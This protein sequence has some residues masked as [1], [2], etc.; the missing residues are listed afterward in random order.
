V[1]V[2]PKWGFLTNHAHVLIEITRRPRATIREIALVA[3][4]TER[5]TISVLHDL[6][7]EG[8][9]SSEREGRRNVYRVHFQA[10]AKHRP[11]GASE[12]EIPDELIETTVRALASL[13]AA[14]E[15][16]P[17]PAAAAT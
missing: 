13:S 10:L 11:W 5:A 1:I 16:T 9:I 15:A 12:L 4:I 2:V 6:R 17:E 3:G 14:G 7:R 8:I